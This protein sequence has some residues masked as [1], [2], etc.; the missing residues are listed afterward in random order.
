MVLTEYQIDS[1]R[2][3][4]VQANLKEIIYNE[5]LPQAER[6]AAR[7][8]LKK[9]IDAHV[10]R[11]PTITGTFEYTEEDEAEAKSAGF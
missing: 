7:A 2:L 11:F 9:E 1:R 4:E 6:D 3:L 8:E 10:Q 5:N